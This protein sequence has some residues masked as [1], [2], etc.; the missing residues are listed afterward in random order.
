MRNLTEENITQAVLGQIHSNDSRTQEVV[1]ALVRHLHAFIREVEPTEAEWFQGIQFL[2]RVGHITDDKRQEFVLLSD[3]L[4]VTILVDAINHRK[5]EGKTESTVFGPFWVAGANEMPHGKN[6]ARGPERDR[7]EPAVVHG[8]ITDMQ[9]MPI[10]GARV[11]VWQ[12]SDDGFYDVQDS[13]QPEMNLRG[14]FKSNADGSYWFRTVKPS[15][16]PI[17]DDGPVGDMLKATGRHPMRPAHIHFMIEA[18]GYEKLITHIFVEGDEYLQS[19]AVFGVKDSLV[20]DF[21][22]NSSADAAAKYEF[23]TIPFYEVQFDFALKK[24]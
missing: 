2:T 11:D 17:P 20:V 21:K 7:G 3:T 1:S 9:G 19:D 8:H 23:S 15:S 16:Y 10:E 12:A 5:E 14:V 24:L 6:I 22:P 13:N 18:S 4:G